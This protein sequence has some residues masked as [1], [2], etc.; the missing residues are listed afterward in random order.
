MHNWRRYPSSKWE[1]MTKNAVL[2]LALCCGAIWR[3]REKPQHRCTTKVHPVYNCSKKILE[4]L[5]PIG[6]VVRT[7]LFIPSRFWT[8]NTNF[9]TCC[10]RYV[11]TCWKNLYRCTSTFTALNYCSGIFF[12]SL[13]Y[14]HEVVHTN[15]SADFWTFRNFWP[16]FCESCGAT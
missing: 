10:Q 3:L 1:K 7:N 15:F 8:T 4:N 5:L 2:N 6:L 14:L 12:K 11:A 13:S 9:H 16:Q